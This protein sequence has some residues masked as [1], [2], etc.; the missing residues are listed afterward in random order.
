MIFL[1]SKYYEVNWRL[2]RGLAFFFFLVLIKRTDAHFTV[3]LHEVCCVSKSQEPK[4]I[5][6]KPKPVYLYR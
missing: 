4:F 1:G 2:D 6:N 5:Q 3:S